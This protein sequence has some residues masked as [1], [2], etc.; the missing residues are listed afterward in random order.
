MKKSKR[1]NSFLGILIIIF[2][3]TVLL[4]SD[5]L[6]L[7]F[8]NFFGLLIYM[9]EIIPFAVLL[10]LLGFF[11]IYPRKLSWLLLFFFAVFFSIFGGKD[12]IVSLIT[13]IHRD[14]YVELFENNNSLPI[15]TFVVL[16]ILTYLLK[17]TTHKNKIEKNDVID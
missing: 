8:N 10:I 2:L 12:H 14:G 9:N 5:F 1:F 17:P 15:L 11:L 13:A 4:T 16:L 6:N 7:Y 3:T